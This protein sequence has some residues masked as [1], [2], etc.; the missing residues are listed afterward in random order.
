MLGHPHNQVLLV[1]WSEQ[2]ELDFLQEKQ[3]ID[4]TGRD[5]LKNTIFWVD[6]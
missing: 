4:I 3:L 2:W 1:P 5:A 6:R